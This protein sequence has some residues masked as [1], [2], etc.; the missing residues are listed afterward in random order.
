LA[1]TTLDGAEAFALS[2]FAQESAPAATAQTTHSSSR[3]DEPN[4][5]YGDGQTIVSAATRSRDVL[6]PRDRSVGLQSE[7]A[8][9]QTAGSGRAVEER[10]GN[11][12][13]GL[14]FEAFEAELCY[15]RPD[16]PSGQPGWR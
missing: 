2:K 8:R 5:S 12:L 13:F 4:E 10:L 1:T 14:G 3:K 9:A 11:L 6:A 15:P 7:R 16:L